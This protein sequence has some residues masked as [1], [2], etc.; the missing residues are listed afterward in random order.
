[1]A[2]HG[3]PNPNFKSFMADNA[4]ANW[5]A[6]RVVYGSGNKLKPMQDRE[7]FCLLH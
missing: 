5:H 2:R 6:V 4:M 7:R 3:V 1:M